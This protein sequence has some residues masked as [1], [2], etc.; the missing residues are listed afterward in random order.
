M[1]F[2]MHVSSRRNAYEELHSLHLL[3]AQLEQCS[4]LH[5]Q[6]LP[7]SVIYSAHVSHMFSE[8]HER[9]F[10]TSHAKLLIGISRIDCEPRDEVEVTKKSTEVLSE[11]SVP[12]MVREVELKLAQD[13]QE[14]LQASDA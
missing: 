6:A 2:R 1:S 8:E 3:V 10:V 12:S 9:Q 7:V 11:G 13:G 5:L 14:L 4:S